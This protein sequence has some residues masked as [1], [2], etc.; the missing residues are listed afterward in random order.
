MF[1]IDYDTWYSKK[2]IME[3]LNISINV[4]SRF[5]KLGLEPTKIS[6]EVYVKGSELDKFLL[7]KNPFNVIEN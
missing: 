1:K 6:R 3:M 2:E 7:N 4:F 5:I